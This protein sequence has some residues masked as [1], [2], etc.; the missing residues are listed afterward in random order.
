MLLVAATSG[1]PRPK[2]RREISL[3]PRASSAREIGSIGFAIADVQSQMLEEAIAPI[4]EA[5]SSAKELE[6]NAR[7]IAA[8]LNADGDASRGYERSLRQPLRPPCGRKGEFGPL[9]REDPGEPPA[10]AMA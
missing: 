8:A 7:K 5:L 6:P 2:F 1:D 4:G 3:S 10:S 9:G